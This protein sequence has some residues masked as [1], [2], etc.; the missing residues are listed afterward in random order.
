MLHYESR[1]M[2]LCLWPV[3]KR[4][5]STIVYFA[6]VSSS[7]V[8]GFGSDKIS[9]SVME[10]DSV[11][12][13]TGVET[14][15]QQYIQWYFSSTRIAQITGDLSYI[16][17]DDQCKERFRNR[18]QLDKQTG[19]LTIMTTRTTDTGEYILEIISSKYSHKIFSVS[20]TGE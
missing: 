9:V 8:P 5:H 3:E 10:G 17:T 2:S 7:V 4:F 14:N 20:V 11:T 15:Q 1:D 19:S 6:C 18:L 12:L 13:H 16:C